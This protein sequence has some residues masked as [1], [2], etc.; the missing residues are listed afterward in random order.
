MQAISIQINNQSTHIELNKSSYFSLKSINIGGLSERKSVY[1]VLGDYLQSAP[2]FQGCLASFSLNHSIDHDPSTSPKLINHTVVSKYQLN[3]LHSSDT[4]NV[5][6]HNVQIGCRYS[7]NKVSDINQCS[8]NSCRFNGICSQQ[9]NSTSC[10]C[11][12]TG[13]TGRF[14]ENFGPSIHVS[15]FPE[16]YAVIELNS[17]QN[18][19]LDRLAFGIE[20]THPGTMTLVHIQGQG[21]SPD[22]IQ[23]TLLQNK[24]S[25]SV[26][27]CLT[28]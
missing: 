9:W 15:K 2:R 3:Y 11:S 14:C 5:K 4:Q 24:V 28:M 26:R 22:Y 23:V 10:D 6:W 27:M 21:Q 13:F 17:P 1:P 16:R 20:I 19:T 8:E 18:T 25:G 12:L 7:N